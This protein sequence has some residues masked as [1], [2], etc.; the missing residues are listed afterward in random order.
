[1]VRGGS[2]GLG[3]KIRGLE[4]AKKFAGGIVGEA[5]I[6]AD[7]F[8]VEDGRA[9]KTPHLLF[10]DGIARSR[11]HVAAPGK[12]GAGNLAIEGEEKGEGTLLEG[13]N[14]VAA[15]QLDVIGGSEAIDVCGIDA[16]RLDGIIQFMR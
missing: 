11:Q 10:F 3:R 9:E 1:L 8:L 16:Q 13:E 6:T 2:I 15:A 14:R 12:N 4:L 7:E 5:E